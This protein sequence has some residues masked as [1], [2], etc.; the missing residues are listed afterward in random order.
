MN[1]AANWLG[2]KAEQL[3]IFR[4]LARPLM[5]LGKKIF[6]QG[7]N[8]SADKLKN[9]YYKNNEDDEEYYY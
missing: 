9:M 8:S 6:K 3:P 5:Q 4:A 1:G 2:L 7:I